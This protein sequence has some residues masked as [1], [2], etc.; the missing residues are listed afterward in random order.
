MVDPLDVFAIGH[1]DS[2]LLGCAETLLEALELI[3]K[4]GPGEYLVFSRTTEHKNLYKVSPDGTVSLVAAS[5]AG[6]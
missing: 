2:R 6:Q 5:V 4:T 1:S 3:Q